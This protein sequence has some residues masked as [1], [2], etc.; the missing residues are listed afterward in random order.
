MSRVLVFLYSEQ[1]AQLRWAEM[2]CVGLGHKPFTLSLGASRSDG[3]A[4]F[5]LRRQE[6]IEG[7]RKESKIY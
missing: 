3:L 7:G 6:G 2:A 4:S 5:T 1:R